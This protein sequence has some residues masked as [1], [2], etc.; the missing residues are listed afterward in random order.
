MP[1]VYELPTHLG[2][3]DQ[4]V[5]GLTA[6]QL[7]RLVIGAS[8]A[9]GVWD[10]V[11]GC[12]RRS[13]WQSPQFWPSSAFCSRSSSLE[14]AR[15]ISGCWLGCSSSC[16]R[17]VWSGN[18]APCCSA[19]G[20]TNEQAGRSSSFTP[21]GSVLRCPRTLKSPGRGQHSARG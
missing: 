5:A 13:G 6:R 1:R 14:A 16:C 8:L 9:Y 7:L 20:E 3:E 12:R 10:Q 15:W 19:S 2:V 21:N 17:A 11:P 18:P 4:L